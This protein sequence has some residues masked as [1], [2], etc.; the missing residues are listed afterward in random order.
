[1]ITKIQLPG[2]FAELETTVH[3]YKVVNTSSHAVIVKKGTPEARTWFPVVRTDED[4]T[5]LGEYENLEDAVKKL[6]TEICLQV[7]FFDKLEKVA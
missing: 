3:G 2:T 7:S 5:V 1:M 6:E 4:S